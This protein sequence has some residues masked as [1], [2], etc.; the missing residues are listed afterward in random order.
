MSQ[1]IRWKQRFDNLHNAYAFLEKAVNVGTYDELQAAGLV[2]TFEFTFELSWKTLKDYLD[3]SGI[4]ASSPREAIKQAFAAKLIEDGHL[5]IEMLDKR[6][7][8]THTYNEEQAK[9]AIDL[10]RNEYFPGI[11]Q[12]YKKLKGLY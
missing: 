2:Q 8:L 3:Y 9:K 6:N 4:T 12:V 5:W 7:Q 10:I 11:T 1:D